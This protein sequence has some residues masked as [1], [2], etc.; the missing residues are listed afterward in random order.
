VVQVEGYVYQFMV[1]G[2]PGIRFKKPTGRPAQLTATQKAEL[3]TLL[4]A[5]PQACGFSGG[6]WRTPLIQK[7][8]EAGC[9]GRSSPPVF[10]I[11]SEESFTSRTR[12]PEAMKK[13]G[14]GY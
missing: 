11:F 8:L 10:S 4:Q 6:C 3:K 7:R 14:A 5:G 12:R 9:Q 13:G 1:Y 2:L